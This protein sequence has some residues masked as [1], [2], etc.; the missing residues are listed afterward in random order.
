MFTYGQ[1]AKTDKKKRRF[2]KYPDACGQDLGCSF[3]KLTPRPNV[4]LSSLS[5]VR[6]M[7]SSKLGL[8]QTDR[9][10]EDRLRDKCMIYMIMS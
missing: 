9:T 5:L 4:E 6:L 1:T 2:K 8:L 7:K 3:C 10:S